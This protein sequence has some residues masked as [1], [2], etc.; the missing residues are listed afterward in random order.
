M[1]IWVL[2]ILH[3][4]E[5]SCSTH[6]TE[7]GACLGAI[8]DLFGCLNVGAYHQLENPDGEELEWRVDVIA[9]MAR[10]ELWD[11]F[12]EY[13]EHTWDTDQQYQVSVE[14]TKVAA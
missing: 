14:K 3:E 4:G 1:N 11:L 10:P 6:L 13:S 5:L 7:K 9:K 2:Q 12:N 8:G